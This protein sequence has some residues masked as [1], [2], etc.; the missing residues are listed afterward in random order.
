MHPFSFSAVDPAARVA[1][2]AAERNS[3]S[4]PAVPIFSAS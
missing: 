1:A 3:R 4:S 2:H